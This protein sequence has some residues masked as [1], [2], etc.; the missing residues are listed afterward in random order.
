ML[1]LVH[2]L[3]ESAWRMTLRT[4]G[5]SFY[6]SNQHLNP[7]DISGFRALYP[8]TARV[9]IEKIRTFGLTTNLVALSGRV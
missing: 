8:G 1:P 5:R 4:L 7:L 3:P 6:A 2:Y 9:R